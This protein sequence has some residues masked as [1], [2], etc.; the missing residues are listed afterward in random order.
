MTLPT[1]PEWIVPTLAEECT[2][3]PSEGPRLRHPAHPRVTIP[4]TDLCGP[5]HKRFPGVLGDLARFWKPLQE[6]HIRMPTKNYAADRVSGGGRVDVG[7]LWNPHART[8]LVAIEEWTRYLI[9]T[10]L[11]ER[12]F[13]DDEPLGFT[14]DEH[15]EDTRTP[16]P[17]AL[18]MLAT[19]HARWLSSYPRLGPAWL[20]DATH[21][22]TLA[23]RALD[24][25]S[26][27]RVNMTGMFC[28][29]VV[30]DLEYGQEICGAQMAG[31]I[32]DDPTDGPAVII[33]S[34]NPAHQTSRLER[35][36]WLTR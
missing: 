21:L 1:Y 8:A 6:A 32:H 31:I 23:M 26:V 10:V 27:R 35:K 34:H 17:L 15:L 13:F 29:E 11:R 2:G 36:D 20:D 24:R 14:V 3:F 19:H 16:V 28:E 33:C 9:R 22:R 5:C 12:R 30:Q 25:P 18:A 7:A 4:G